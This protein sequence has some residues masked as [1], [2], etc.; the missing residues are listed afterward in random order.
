MDVLF[1]T[2]YQVH[3]PYYGGQNYFIE[4]DI[5]IKVVLIQSERVSRNLLHCG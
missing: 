5:L 3:N 4:R 2:P 1:W